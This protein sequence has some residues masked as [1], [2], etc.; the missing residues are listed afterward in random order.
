MYKKGFPRFLRYGIAKFIFFAA[1]A[2]LFVFAIGNIVMYLWNWILPDAIGANEI[3]FWKAIG[4]FILTRI[5]FGGF[6]S[7]KSHH[8]RRRSRRWKDKWMNLPKE[9]REEFKEMWKGGW[10]D[11]TAEERRAFKLKWKEAFRKS[12]K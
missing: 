8:Y 11:M 2:V 10:K 7:G 9:E 6:R 12:W 4:L 1:M 5:L 3:T